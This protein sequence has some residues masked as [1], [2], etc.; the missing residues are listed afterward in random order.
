ME[1]ISNYILL[2][3]HYRIMRSSYRAQFEISLLK[4]MLIKII[5]LFIASLFGIK[6]KANKFFWKAIYKERCQE[7]CRMKLKNFNRCVGYAI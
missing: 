3:N 4:K 7:S 5:Y 6:E 1:N 2:Q